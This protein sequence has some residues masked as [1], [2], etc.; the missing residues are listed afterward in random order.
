MELNNKLIHPDTAV[1][2]TSYTGFKNPEIKRMML[3]S[4]VNHLDDGVTFIC[5]ASHSPVDV[6]T[7]N[8]CN[9]VIYDP[10][11]SWQICGIPYRP[12]HGVAELT[13]IHNGIN[14]LKRFGFK[15]ILK[16]CFDVCPVVNY[17]TMIN[18]CKAMN[19]K[20]VTYENATDLGTLMFFSE[21]EFFE[22]HFH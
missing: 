14:A 6:E 13:S 12:N 17:N 4:L 19:K 5:V 11:N 16:Q 1:L 15:Y 10:N 8:H 7:Q 2:I 9:L 20:L 18:K 22:K 3:N 21:I